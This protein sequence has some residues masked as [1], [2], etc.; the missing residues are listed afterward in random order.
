MKTPSIPRISAVMLTC[1]RPEQC[2]HCVE[3]NARALASLPAEIL[4]IN[5]TVCPPPTFSE[6]SP[7]PVRLI[8][9]PVAGG[10]EARNLAL[11]HARGDY[12]LFLDDDATI[13]TSMIRSAMQAMDY[14]ETT[15]I[16]CFRVNNAQTEEASLLPTVF[17][18]CAVMIRRQ[19][20]SD[21]G[22]YPSNFGYYAEEYDIAFRIFSAGYRM[23]LLNTGERAQHLRVAQGR[24]LSRILRLLVRN[25][26]F[27]CARFFSG[28]FLQDALMDVVQRYQLI[29]IKEHIPMAFR[30]GLALLPLALWRGWNQ[31]QPL[32]EKLR[33][34]ITRELLFDSFLAELPRDRHVPVLLCG[35]G[36][37]PRHHIRLVQQAG[38]AVTAFA[39]FNPC[40][41]G[42][43]IRTVPVYTP[44]EALAAYPRAQWINGCA[45]L[46]D[47]AQW[48]DL[49]QAESQLQHSPVSEKSTAPKEDYALQNLPDLFQFNNFSCCR[50]RA[51][52][53]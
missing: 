49:L 45:S 35:T 22:G 53:H 6:T 37:F 50:N 10:A 52:S 18:G 28:L 13:S 41:H 32:T 26:S 29:C 20:L 8:Q 7:T 27:V 25:N 47:S 51:S 3:A 19:A 30:Q 11:L 43:T 36:R 24:N 38:L 39:D 34:Q 2:R 9:N 23:R 5:N 40:W 17:H 31:R 33:A 12:F 46:A 16:V 48:H 14:D 21:A 44:Q 15:G 42:Q 1:G 4:V